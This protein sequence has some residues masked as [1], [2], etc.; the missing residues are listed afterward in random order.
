[1]NAVNLILG[2]VN[3]VV[4]IALFLYVF[5]GNGRLGLESRVAALEQADVGRNAI[6]AKAIESMAIATDGAVARLTE[7]VESVNRIRD[8]EAQIPE[9]MRRLGV[10]LLEFDKRFKELLAHEGSVLDLHKRVEKLERGG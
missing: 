6:L 7:A 1:M 4:T 5:R 2:V 8:A 10:M 3:V 9:T